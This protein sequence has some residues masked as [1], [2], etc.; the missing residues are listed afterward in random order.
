[1]SNNRSLVIKED[2]LFPEINALQVA[3]SFNKLV[4]IMP[5]HKE[6][7][8]VVKKSLPEIQRS[9]SLFFKTQSQAMDNLMTVSAYTPLRNLRQ[10]LAQMNST[11]AAI[12]EAQFKLQKKDIEVR[13]KK[14]SL[15]KF[16]NDD[17]TLKNQDND[18]D[19]ELLDL[20][21]AEIVTNADDTRG[22]IS[23]AI[24]TLTNYTEQ[25]NNIV[26]AHGIGEWTEADF[27]KE[28]EK[29]HIM[30]AFEQAVCAARSRQGT[31][32][33]GNMIYLTQIGINGTTAQQFVMNYLRSE[34]SV[35]DESRGVNVPTHKSFRNFLEEMARIFTGCTAEFAAAKGMTTVS[36]VALIQQGDMRLLLASKNEKDKT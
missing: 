26:K 28:E 34:Q 14:R 36:P 1:M 2:S 20:E 31:I 9:T 22:Y 30:K 35:I 23:G 33:E 24:R 7:L 29:Y 17:G 16:L 6:M 4:A 32:D 13:T 19:V 18:L 12:K 10:I 27:E 3:D 25:Y 11:R 21:I 8:E 5:E 15:A